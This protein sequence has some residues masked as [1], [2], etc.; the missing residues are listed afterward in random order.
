MRTP[1]Q[2][3]AAVAAIRSGDRRSRT[4]GAV[5]VCTSVT[6]LDAIPYSHGNAFRYVRS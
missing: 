2:P 6:R 3:T 4:D 1:Q 5:A